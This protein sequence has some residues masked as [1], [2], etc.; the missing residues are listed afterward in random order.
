MQVKKVG[1]R[2]QK[3][4]LHPLSEVSVQYERYHHGVPRYAPEAKMQAEGF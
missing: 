4:D 2:L 1:Q 3:S